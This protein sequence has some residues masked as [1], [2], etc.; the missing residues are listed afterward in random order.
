MAAVT[1]RY[2]RSEHELHF[3]TERF[4][5]I[6]YGNEDP[7][8]SDAEIGAKLDDP[9]GSPPLEDLVAAD[10]TVLLVVPDATRDTGSGQVVNLVVR[11]LIA[12][13][14]A[15]S[16]IS[17]IFATGIH[18]PVTYPEKQTLVTPFIAQRIKMIDHRAGDPTK[19]F[20]LGETSGGIPV[21]LNWVVTEFDRIVLIGGVTYHYFAGFT[22]SRKLI[23]P[24][25]ASERTISATHKLAFDC[26]S[27]SRR[28]GVGTALLDGNKVHEA[29]VE[30]AAFGKP[31]FCINTIVNSGGEVTDIF[32]GDWIESHLAACDKFTG[33][34]TVQIAEKRNIVIASCNGFPH[35]INM[36]QTHKALEAASHACSEGGT[37]V[38]MAE[39]VE[40]PGQDDFMDWFGEGG[41]EA[42]A[43]KLCSDYKVNG[44][45]AWS[46]STKTERFN[47]L[48]KTGLEKSQVERTGMKKVSDNEIAS[49]MADPALSGYIIPSGAKFQFRVL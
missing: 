21:E 6:G 42:I 9:I 37:I 28:P 15:P 11:R 23:C 3:D 13:G 48:I 1:L 8:L 12:S 32:C 47:V 49:L 7:G 20:R 26:D 29:F 22:G 35:D 38:L 40:G 24:G 4:E 36:I 45:T 25:L 14:V 18:R 43:D 39:C 2:G 27:R 5:V 44:Q 10:E 46:L 16:N 33:D 30:A 34:H 19:L 41:S 17:I 31:A